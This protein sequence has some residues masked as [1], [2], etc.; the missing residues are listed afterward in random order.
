MVETTRGRK[1][2]LVCIDVYCICIHKRPLLRCSLA[3][4]GKRSRP[5]IDTL[6]DTVRLALEYLDPQHWIW[7]SANTGACTVR[8]ARSYLAALGDAHRVQGV[9]PRG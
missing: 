1:L 9:K 3:P 6:E 2:V 4:P 8:L 7:R 5:L